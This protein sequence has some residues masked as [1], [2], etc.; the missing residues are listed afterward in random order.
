MPIRELEIYIKYKSFREIIGL[1]RSNIFKLK[2]LQIL[3]ESEANIR[4]KE[5]VSLWE[6]ELIDANGE[7]IFVESIAKK[8]QFEGQECLLNSF[9]EISDRKKVEEGKLKAEK[10][11]SD[12]WQFTI[13]IGAK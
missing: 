3:K 7:F 11:E 1:N 2:E 13:S 6:L 9:V 4:D 10:Q 8:I 5:L 12:K